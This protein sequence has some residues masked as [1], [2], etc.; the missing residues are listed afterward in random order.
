VEIEEPSDA[1]S[2][3]CSKGAVEQNP[4]STTL[5]AKLQGQVFTPSIYGTLLA[6][7]GLTAND[8]RL[9]FDASR[10]EVSI[11]SSRKP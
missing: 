10:G 5:F 2:N 7:S 11:F 4:G 3:C 1:L 6:E 8:I 9:E